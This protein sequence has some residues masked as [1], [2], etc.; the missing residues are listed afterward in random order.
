MRHA[1]FGMVLCGLLVSVAA[2]GDKPA[3]GKPTPLPHCPV[4]DEPVDFSISTM[5]ADG[6][7]YFCCKKCVRMFD[8]KPTKYAKKVTRQRT[9]LAKMNKVQVSCP[10]SGEPIDPEVTADHAGGKVAFCCGK[11]RST[12]TAAPAKFS[13]KLAGSYTYQT[14]C[15]VMGEEIDPESWID[16][17]TGQRIYLCCPPCGKKL[18][19]NPD[20]YADKLAAQGMPINVAKIKA[21]KK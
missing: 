18:M 6:P 11:C 14:I 8:K 9:Q 1:L 7:V 15:P 20:K 3:S 2:A 16:L 12:F 21:K 10:V 13:A 19:K 17:P 4:M 5:T